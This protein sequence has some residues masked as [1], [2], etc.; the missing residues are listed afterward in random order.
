[1][2]KKNVTQ[3]VKKQC[4]HSPEERSYYFS[5]DNK[6][7]LPLEA[8]SSSISTPQMPRTPNYTEKLKQ[9]NWG[10]IPITE[11]YLSL[12]QKPFFQPKFR[13]R[14]ENHEKESESESEKTSKKTS[15]RPVIGTS[16][17]SRN[18]EIHDQEEKLNIR[19][20]IFSNAQG[21]IIP[22]PLRPINPPARNNDKMAT[23][24]IA[25]LTD[26]SGEEEKKMDVHTW[27]REAQKAI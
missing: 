13:A 23:P 19:E 7:Q 5:L 12:F 9:H 22:F 20:V 24:Y 2:P 3:L 11:G 18:Q 1:M 27:L 21:N 17:Q 8:A 6:I 15:T 10:D 14:F 25:R 26:F 4:F 16:S